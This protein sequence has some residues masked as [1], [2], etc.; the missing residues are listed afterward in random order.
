MADPQSNRLYTYDYAPGLA[1]HTS[2]PG[3]FVVCVDACSYGRMGL[4]SAL[5]HLPFIAGRKRVVGVSSLD[6]ALQ[7]TLPYVLDSQVVRCLVVRLP[8]LT[9]EALIVLLQLSEMMQYAVGRYHQVVVLSP[10]DITGVQPLLTVMGMANVRIVD[11]RLS[12][13]ALCS[14]VFSG[15][16]AWMAEGWLLSHELTDHERSVLRKTLQFRSIPQQARTRQVSVKTVYSQ[17]LSALMK[18]GVQDIRSLL[19]LLTPA[20]KE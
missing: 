2:L 4:H 13:S 5:K 9:R 17:R 11:A 12:L 8:S 20:K 6:E 16:E 1:R 15:T 14:A 3:W 10:F 7:T 19:N 18:L